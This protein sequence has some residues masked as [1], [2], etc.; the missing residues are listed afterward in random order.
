M[1][2]AATAHKGLD[3]KAF[4]T[5]TLVAHDD[6][7]AP[8]SKDES[9]Y[10]RRYV[11]GRGQS[12]EEQFDTISLVSRPAPTPVPLLKLQQPTLQVCVKTLNG[13]TV[14]IATYG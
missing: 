3:M 2:T 14:T 12:D 7:P 6:R 5:P 13:K 4:H 9:A 10:P 8:M 1:I 11:H